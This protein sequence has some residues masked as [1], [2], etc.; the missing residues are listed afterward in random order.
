MPAFLLTFLT[1]ALA[2]FAGRE[3]V[4]TARL[5]AGG[6]PLGGL[7]LAIAGAAVL[8]SAFAAWLAGSLANLVT[9]DYRSWFV[10]AAL[11]LAA[12]EV[13]LLSTAKTPREPTAS[14]GATALV[15]LSGIATDASGLLI[16][17]LALAT[18]APALAAAGGA[19]A[20]IGVL[21]FAAIAGED[22][23]RMPRRALRWLVVLA[24]TVGAG[25]VALVGRALF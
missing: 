13:A 23:E 6:A 25:V 5:A 1:V 22:W 12:L 2:M 15:L 16:L 14:I 19:L 24:L 17:S 7:L 8:A 3:A 21:G 4:R 11:A 9:G 18:G 10:A 20:V